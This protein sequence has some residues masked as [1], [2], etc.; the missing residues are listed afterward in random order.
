MG[1]RWCVQIIEKW[2][3]RIEKHYKSFPQ[4]LNDAQE[5]SKCGDHG[6]K[7]RL[8]EKTKRFG[9]IEFYEIGIMAGF[10]SYRNNNAHKIKWNP[11]RKNDVQRRE[12]LERITIGTEKFDINQRAELRSSLQKCARNLYN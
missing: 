7:N 9:N 3:E 1:E 6:V 10:K 4:L 8:T 11:G 12:V 5:R 2:Q